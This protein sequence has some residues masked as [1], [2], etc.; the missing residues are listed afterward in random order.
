[1]KKIQAILID[2]FTETLSYV[3][4]QEHN[5]QDYYDIMQCTCFDIVRLGGGVIMFLD[6]EG[7]LKENRYFKLGSAN[8]AGRSIVANETE[9]GGTTDCQVTIEQVSENLVWL[10]KGHK[11]NP[12]RFVQLARR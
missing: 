8:F 10:P 5:L 11:E 12:L 1:M 4:V 9:D 6:D 3:L 2:P 7:V